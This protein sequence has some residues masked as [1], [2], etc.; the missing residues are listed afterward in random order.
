MRR[1]ELREYLRTTTDKDQQKGAEEMQKAFDALIDK[2]LEKEKSIF[3]ETIKEV[4]RD[5][6]ENQ[7]GSSLSNSIRGNTNSSIRYAEDPLKLPTTPNAKAR[8]QETARAKG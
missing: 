2:K 1:Q 3:N 5:Y 4:K 6:S 8:G 7:K